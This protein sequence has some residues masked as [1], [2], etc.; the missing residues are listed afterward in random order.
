MNRRLRAVLR[1][2]VVLVLIL[3]AAGIWFKVKYD[4]MVK[5]FTEA[6]VAPVDLWQIDD[7]TYAGSFG[8]FLVSVE[9]EVTVQNN[10]I[11]DLVII[12]QHCGPGYRALE[13]MD[14]IVAAQSPL[15]DVVTGATGS[16]R[17]IMI[18]TYLALT[19]AAS[20]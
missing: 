14:R 11:V 20:D 19:E 12:D 7:G 2:L 13:T 17:C 3:A 18:A 16:S 1:V 8:E 6:E 15:V 4:R 5:V 9:L 10:R